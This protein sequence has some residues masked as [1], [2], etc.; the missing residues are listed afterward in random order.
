M[1]RAAANHLAGVGVG[2]RALSPAATIVGRDTSD[3]FHPTLRRSGARPDAI[4]GAD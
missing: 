3:G 4:F 1:A 2:V